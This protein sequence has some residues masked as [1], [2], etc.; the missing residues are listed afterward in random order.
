MPTPAHWVEFAALT[1]V[2]QELMEAYPEA[3]RLR[4]APLEVGGSICQVHRAQAD[5]P[6]RLMPL[7]GLS[8]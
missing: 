6:L 5:A 3:E 2:N 7:R 4:T 1:V 8:H